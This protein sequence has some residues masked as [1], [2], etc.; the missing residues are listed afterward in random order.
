MNGNTILTILRSIL[1]LTIW[2]WAIIMIGPFIGDKLI[3][4]E[5]RGPDSLL[6]LYEYY[7]LILGKY[8]FAS[9]TLGYLLIRFF[10]SLIDEKLTETKNNSNSSK[11]N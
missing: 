11:S 8:W 6:E 1:T 7:P 4:G 9:L 3:T 10:N 5:R 2:L